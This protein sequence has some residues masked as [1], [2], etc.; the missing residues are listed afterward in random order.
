MAIV[1]DLHQNPP[2]FFKFEAF[3]FLQNVAGQGKNDGEFNFEYDRSP[4]SQVLI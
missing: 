2:F 3:L 4:L 1:P